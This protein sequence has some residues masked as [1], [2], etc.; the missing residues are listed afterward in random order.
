VL[1][2]SKYSFLIGCIR[3]L[4]TALVEAE[5]D[6]EL[7]DYIE[8]LAHSLGVLN[9]R[10]GVD[11]GDDA[12]GDDESIDDVDAPGDDTPLGAAL[13]RIHELEQ[14]LAATV[15]KP[16]SRRVVGGGSPDQGGLDVGRQRRKSPVLKK[17]A[18]RGK[19]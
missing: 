10:W 8:S 12:S 2:K 6:L 5:R 14:G 7:A 11:L 18:R 19:K 4:E 15:D 17:G 3:Q 9:T 16:G 1:D 13:A